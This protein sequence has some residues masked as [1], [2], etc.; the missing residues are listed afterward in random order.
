MATRLPA[1]A[2][3]CGEGCLV[4]GEGGRNDRRGRARYPLGVSQAEQEPRRVLL[5]TEDESTKG[6]GGCLA[7]GG[8]LGV[9][10][11]IMFALYGL[12]PILKHYYGEKNVA[13]GAVYE[14]DG[15]TLQVVSVTAG[16]DPLT[17]GTE[18]A[19]SAAKAVIVVTVRSTGWPENEPR[20]GRYRLEVA[21]VHDWLNPLPAIEAEVQRVPPLAA[22]EQEVWLRF[23][24]PEGLSAQSVRPVE[25]HLEEPRVKFQLPAVKVLEE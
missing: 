4:A 11:G 9:I 16:F 18:T 2:S 5:K 14:K 10:F 22:G 17:V 6:R 13:V 1:R 25:L 7:L 8:V 19:G 20:Q 21:D 24:M 12:P 3:L 23:A 15:R